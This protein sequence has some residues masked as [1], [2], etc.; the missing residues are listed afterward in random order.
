MER[1]N[2]DEPELKPTPPKEARGE[3]CLKCYESQGH[4]C[5]EYICDFCDQDEVYPTIKIKENFKKH[6]EH[7][8]DDTHLMNPK[9]DGRWSFFNLNK[10]WRVSCG[11]TAPQWKILTL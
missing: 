9:Y 6:W 7:T 1:Q 11:S 10:S 8:H 3:K 2:F 5:Q 4:H